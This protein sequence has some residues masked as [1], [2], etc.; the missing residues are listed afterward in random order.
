MI[1]LIDQRSLNLTLRE[2]SGVSF[3]KREKDLEEI[4][5]DN[6]SHEIRTPL[7]AII[8]FNDLLNGVAGQHMSEDEKIVMKNHIHKNADRLLS[9]MDDILD[10]S[11]MEKGEMRLHKTIVS[12]MEICYKVREGVKYEVREGVKLMHEYPM[13]LKDTRLY[14]D[15][16]RLEQILHHFLQNACEHTFKGAILLKVKSFLDYESHRKMLELRVSDTGEGIPYDQ[17][18]LLFLP[19]RKLDGKSEGLGMGLALCKQLAKMLG[20]R[21]YLDET[22]VGGSSFVLEIPFDEA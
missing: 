10:L 1:K 12:L 16:K 5:L 17:R 9:V 7:N 19:F 20:G 2:M 4:F 3:P 21:V 14:T 18:E 15:G 8:G 6:L 13:A 22:Y 11:R